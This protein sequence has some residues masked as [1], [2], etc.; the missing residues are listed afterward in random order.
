MLVENAC[1]I[2]NRQKIN[3][4]SKCKSLQ[5]TYKEEAIKS[6]GKQL[7]LIH[8]NRH[9]RQPRYIDISKKSGCS[10]MRNLKRK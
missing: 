7:N 1:N 6:K 9:E 3:I 2:H 10:T 8:M 4:Q 5:I